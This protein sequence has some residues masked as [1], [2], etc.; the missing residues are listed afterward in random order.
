MVT[1]EMISYKETQNKTGAVKYFYNREDDYF[2]HHIHKAQGSKEECIKSTIESI[3]ETSKMYLVYC[4]DDVAAFFVKYVG[5]DGRMALEGFHVLPK[6]RNREFLTEFWKVI[7]EVFGGPFFCGLYCKNE[8]AI[9]CLA[10]AG[11]RVMNLVFIY[12]MAFIIFKSE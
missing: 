9:R 5:D 6:F 8:P 10:K 4:G 3:D 7:R 2:F 1:T 11:F 12:D